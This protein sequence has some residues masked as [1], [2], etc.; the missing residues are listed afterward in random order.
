MNASVAGESPASTAILTRPTAEMPEV[1]RALTQ[2]NMLYTAAEVVIIDSPEMYRTA[3]DELNALRGKWRAME[4]QRKHL[5]EPFLEGG[6]RIDEFF[7]APLERIA[8]A[9]KLIESR[10][11]EYKT[12]Q[13]R[14]AEEKRR[15]AE[16][17]ARREREELERQQREAEE[18]ARKAREQAEREAREARERAD[19]ER[20]QREAEA[21]AA[22]KAG[23]EEA[24]RRA[25]EDARSA[26]EQAEREAEAARQR[27]QEIEAEQA[28]KAAEAQAQLDIA[29]VAPVVVEQSAAVATGVS[30]RTTWKVKSVDKAALVKAAAEQLAAGDDTLLAYLLVDEKALNGVA[31]ALKSAARVPGVV[32]AP[33]TSMA[34]TGRRR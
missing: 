17:L 4:D 21:E 30:A 32:F 6:R 33:E 10:M 15:A 27:A 26:Q 25:E 12:E 16:E 7:K 5:K 20:R 3:A 9:G 24:A 19:A 11:V 22:R 34:A 29:E 1:K 14:I 18:E 31:R 8:A 2:A 23:D 13:D 28:Q